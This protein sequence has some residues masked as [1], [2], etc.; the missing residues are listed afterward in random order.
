MDI[1]GTYLFNAPRDEV[2]K[3]ILDPDVLSN[4][5]P[6]IQSL[7][8]IGEN[9]YRAVM[10][11]RI[12]PVQGQFNGTVELVDLNPPVGYHILLDASGAQGF[13]KGEGDLE[14]VEQDDSTELHYS[15]KAQVG[16]RIASVGQRLMESSAQALVQ[17]GLQAFDAQ[18]QAR[19]K[20]E[21]IGAEALVV[22][23]P[24]E[25]EF[26]LGVTQKMIQDLVP[27]ERRGEILRAGIA[28]IAV[29][30]FL[31]SISDWWT[32]RLAHRVAEVLE[33]RGKQ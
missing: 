17:Q 21:E 3:A 18:I 12:G 7:E 25:M 30:V 27:E 13:V 22:E 5:L 24:S 28:L 26:A 4:S 23:A 10:K 8:S 33:E 15:G 2:W 1:K 20:G 9:K 16:G 31:K 14:L 6:G 19:V 29:L 32:N 11:V